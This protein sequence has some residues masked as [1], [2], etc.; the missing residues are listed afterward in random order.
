M[1]KSF[2]VSTSILVLVVVTALIYLLRIDPSQKDLNTAILEPLKFERVVKDV[3]FEE[4]PSLYTSDIEKLFVPGAIEYS[5]GKYFISEMPKAKVYVYNE[6]WA[7]EDSIGLGK[8]RGPGE[9]NYILDFSISENTIYVADGGG[10]SVHAFKT[11]GEFINS[12]PY[13]K[14]PTRLV[15]TKDSLIILNT[16]PGK[17]FSSIDNKSLEMGSEFG[18]FIDDQELNFMSL[19]GHLEP[20]SNGGFI[21]IP[22]HQSLIYFFSDS[23]N[24]DFITRMP[25]GEDFPIGE[26]RNTN[27]SGLITAPDSNS[28]S[29]ETSEYEDKLYIATYVRNLGVKGTV[30]LD[31]YNID[32]GEYLESYKM[33]RSCKDFFVKDDIFTC[34]ERERN[35]I[36]YRIISK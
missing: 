27:E 19:F 25:D 8:G 1:N 34:V 17:L 5:N 9:L 16:S 33:P 3:L 10:L 30:F 11:N 15:S 7:L 29:F 4:N 35:I 36:S 21:Y 32:N 13:K 14:N 22:M 23:N 2:I 28:P 12:K 31:I 6:E 26:K 20:R 18:V 24:I